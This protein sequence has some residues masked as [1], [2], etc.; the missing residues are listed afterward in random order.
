MSDDDGSTIITVKKQPRYTPVDYREELSLCA[1]DLADLRILSSSIQDDDEFNNYIIA[2]IAIIT[3]LK[4]RTC[5]CHDNDDMSIDMSYVKLDQCML[6]GLGT[7]SDS[8]L[9]TSL[10]SRS[11]KSSTTNT[12][13]DSEISFHIDLLVFD[14]L[15]DPLYDLGEFGSY[16][17]LIGAF[18]LLLGCS[19]SD[20]DS[21][22]DTVV[23]L[24]TINRREWDSVKL[25]TTSPPKNRTIEG[26]GPMCY[27]LTRF[28]L[29]ELKKLKALFFG[30]YDSNT[31]VFCKNKFTFEE[32]MLIAL[33]YMANGTKYITMSMTYGGDW[34]RYSLITIWFSKFVFHKY[35]HRLS[36][37]SLSYFLDE[38]IV[39]VC[40]EKI[41]M[42]ITHDKDN[43]II[44]DL[45]HLNLSCNSPQILWAS[46]Y[47]RAVA[48]MFRNA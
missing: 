33:D 30:E 1:Q 42:Y 20:L 18:S 29:D 17:E 5:N 25:T 43:A 4:E 9:A 34:T 22:M 21:V 19:M 2:L 3:V 39:D 37:R 31:Y 12:S 11:S 26:L 6:E 7:S 40:R 16:A 46:K 28:T 41:F 27:H 45:S 48:L 14:N 35:Y 24:S 47:L 8:S 32:T 36:G 23:N 15:P 44:P 38:N 13:L 10:S